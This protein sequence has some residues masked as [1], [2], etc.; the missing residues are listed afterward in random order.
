MSVRL[1][2]PAEEEGLAILQQTQ[3]WAR[4]RLVPLNATIEVTQRCNIR[5]TH[6][7][8]FDRDAD[9]KQTSACPSR[10]DL[11]SAEILALIDDLHREGCFFLSLTG[12]E[13]MLHP[14]FFA[15]LDRAAERNMAVHVLSNGTLLRPGMVGRLAGYPNL[16]KISLSLYGATAEV[17][18][19]IT[20]APGSWARTWAGAER[21]RGRGIGV[22][23]KF[24]VM[25]HNAHQVEAMIAS[26]DARGFSYGVDLTVTAR[27]DGDPGSLAVR[28]DR[29]QLEQLCRGPLQ[30]HLYLGPERPVT[31]S[32]FACNCGRGNCAITAQGDVQPCIAVPLVAG[33]VRQQPFAEIWR[34]SPVFQRL[35]GL[36]LEDYRECAPCPHKS[37]CTRER[38]AAFTYSGSYTGTDP[39]V[40]ARAEITHQLADE[41]HRVQHLKT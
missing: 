25:R 5:C 23:L 26:A 8:N 3:G 27:H 28:I 37:W 7:Y 21:L 19:G 4:N 34:A 2:T 39:L 16:T 33:N 22:R 11:T 13:A 14:D 29:A 38:G 18:D 15:F 35:R 36:R 12:G 17:H 32:T 9:R 40:C 31:S 6:C 24:I 1:R 30:K 10:P 41:L 20:Q